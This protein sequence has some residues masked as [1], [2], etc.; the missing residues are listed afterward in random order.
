MS[1]TISFTHLIAVAVLYPQYNPFVS[2]FLFETKNGNDVKTYSI[3]YIP[4]KQPP[5]VQ[6]PSSEITI[7]RTHFASTQ[8]GSGRFLIGL[9][10]VC[11]DGT[12][13]NMLNPETTD[14]KLDIQTYQ[15][16][17]KRL[18]GFH[19]EQ[20]TESYALLRLDPIWYVNKQ[21]R[22]RKHV[23]FRPSVEIYALDSREE[24]VVEEK[25]QSQEQIDPVQLPIVHQPSRWSR[26][27]VYIMPALTTMMVGYMM[28][29]WIRD[30]KSQP[31]KVS[32]SDPSPLTLPRSKKKLVMR[33]RSKPLQLEYI[34]T[35]KAN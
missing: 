11:S 31:A 33:K 15:S 24:P 35:I 8:D 19:I 9:D 34:S 30:M 10:L 23:T 28:Y 13:V 1:E 12:S 14:V 29:E 18:I 2:G 25:T 26:F 6:L 20:S 5:F 4:D 7:V 17:G 3:G 32:E 16:S 21:D 22:H 27:P